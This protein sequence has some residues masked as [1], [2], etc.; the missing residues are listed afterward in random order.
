M[1]TEIERIIEEETEARLTEMEQPGYVF[2]ETIDKRDWTAIVVAIA[3]SLVL[4]GLC[5]VGV[6]V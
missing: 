4:I 6:I 5:M 2:P 1:A 3:V